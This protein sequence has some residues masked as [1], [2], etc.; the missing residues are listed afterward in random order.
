MRQERTLWRLLGN[1]DEGALLYPVRNQFWGKEGGPGRPGVVPLLL[2]SL[3]FVTAPKG[4]C[5]L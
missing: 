5:S 3:R 1:S 2:P 4:L